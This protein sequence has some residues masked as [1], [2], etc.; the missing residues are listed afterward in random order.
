L[1][2]ALGRPATRGLTGRARP[3][4]SAGFATSASSHPR[5]RRPKA[6][7]AELVDALDS[8]SSSARSAGSIPARGTTLRPSGF[9][10]HGRG[11]RPK[12]KRVWRSASEDGLTRTNT[13]C[14]K[15]PDSTVKQHLDVIARLDRAIQY[16]RAAAI[17][18]PGWSVLDRPL[19]RAMTTE[20]EARPCSSNTASRSRRA[21]RPSF[22]LTSRLSR[23]RAQCPPRGER[24]LPQKGSGES[25]V[26]DAPAAACAKCSK[27]TR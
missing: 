11:Y 24:A 18:P 15:F 2:P 16:S 20:S 8:K 12:V 23:S 19:S 13:R 14:C 10:W 4:Y 6:P 5:G 17:G 22:A 26:P 25:R 21:M 27:H 1:P 9:A 3:L 7:V